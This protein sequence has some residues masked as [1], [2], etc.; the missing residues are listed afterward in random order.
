MCCRNVRTQVRSNPGECWLGPHSRSLCSQVRSYFPS[1]HFENITLHHCRENYKDFEL[2]MG[3]FDM[4]NDREKYPEQKSRVK[5]L[6][7]HPKGIF[8]L[9]LVF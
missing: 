6:I 2:I 9:S 3:E 5:R 8:S 7:V 1:L 4:Y